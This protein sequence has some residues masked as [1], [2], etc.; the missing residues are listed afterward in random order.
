[1][2]QKGVCSSNGYFNQMWLDIYYDQ[3]FDFWKWNLHGRYYTSR[4]HAP[5]MG[6]SLTKKEDLI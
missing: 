6:K 4:Q 1:M 5:P 2:G 3:Y